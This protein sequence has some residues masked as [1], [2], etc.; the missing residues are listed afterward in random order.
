TGLPQELAQL[1][2]SINV[3]LDRLDQGVS[4]LSQF[5]DD[6]AHEL[7]TPLSNLMGKAQVTLARERDNANYREVLEDSIEEL[8]R[9]NR[10]I[11]DMMFL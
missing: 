2:S 3:M 6:L 8:T 7:R 11:N 4:Q 1:A 10:I 5:S 9:L